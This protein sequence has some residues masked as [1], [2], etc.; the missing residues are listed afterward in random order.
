LA[1]HPA[2]NEL[3]AS[4]RQEPMIAAG[5]ELRAI[6][7]QHPVGRLDDAPMRQHPCLGIS[8]V[9]S[10]AHSTVDLASNI[11]LRERSCAPIAHQNWSIAT[12]TINTRMTASPIRVDRLLERNVR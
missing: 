1:A 2:G 12:H 7:E 9:I 8:P 6:L 4:F 11:N 5:N 3:P 10:T